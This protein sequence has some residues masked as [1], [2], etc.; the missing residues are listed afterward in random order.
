MYV[1][2]CMTRN[3]ITIA[4]EQDVAHAVRI[5][6]RHNIRR[7]PVLRGET[8]VGMVSLY[9]LYRSLP[10]NLNPAHNQLPEDLI[11]SIAIEEV[12]ARDVI[13]ATP[14]DPLEEIADIMRTRNIGG[15][16]VIQR[17][18]VVGIITE[19][20]IF[21]ALAGIMGARLGG[22]RITFELAADPTAFTN[23]LNTAHV[24]GLQI[25]SLIIYRPPN[26]AS[27][28]ITLRVSGDPIDNFIESLTKDGYRLTGVLDEKTE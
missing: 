4:P 5:M 27:E 11:T 1:Q 25:H 6:Q 23:L 15:M 28:T 7:L 26:A 3:V 9:Y 10:P 18:R 22:T 13:T 14:R 19:S 12:M 8:L 2:N 16:P 21:Q 20:D 24:F 17:G